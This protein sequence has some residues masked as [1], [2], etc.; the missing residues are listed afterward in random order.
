MTDGAIGGYGNSARFPGVGSIG[1]DV[2]VRPRSGPKG[3]DAGSLAA[4]RD[5]AM[6]T[7]APQ[8]RDRFRHEALL[9][10]GDEEFVEECAAFVADGVAEDEAVMVVVAA[11]KIDRLRTRLGTTAD[12]VRFADM[13]A[14][15][16]NPSRIIGVWQRFF[17]DHPGVPCRG[18]GEPIGPQR[19][20]EELTECQRHEVLL[21]IAFRDTT[22]WIMCP[23]DTAR[24]APPVIAEALRSHPWVAELGTHRHSPNFDPIVG[25]FDDVLTEPVGPVAV[26]QFDIE[27]VGDVQAL[28]AAHP[29]AAALGRE[30]LDDFVLAV[31]EV[32]T[33][34]IRHGD[35]HGTAPSG[36]TARPCSARSPIP[37]TSSTHSWGAAYR[38]PGE[39]AGTD[40]GS[41]TISAISCSCDRTPRERPCACRSATPCEV[42]DSRPAARCCPSPRALLHRRRPHG[43]RAPLRPREC[44]PRRRP[45]RLGVAV[46]G[47]RVQALA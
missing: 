25:P 20:A 32:A 18:I 8:R 15:G 37:G 43:P 45:S 1:R 24:L 33:N 41:R 3:L 13:T 39:T 47:C 7:A 46:S 34:S 19:S 44:P 10:A 2:Q 14:V 28:L 30:R 27:T 26:L 9:Y 12:T 16:R 6:T 23:Y 21:N 22:G 40:S 42:S 5:A 29:A 35:G 17:A 36:A 11:P 4:A 38:A 31:S